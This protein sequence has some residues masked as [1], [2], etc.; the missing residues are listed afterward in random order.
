MSMLKQTTDHSL[1][2][3]STIV[4]ETTTSVQEEPAQP[5]N[6]VRPT[7]QRSG[8]TCSRSIQATPTMPNA[9]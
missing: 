6:Y 5:N 2:P 3:A 4:P 1:R 8:K 7:L 9:L